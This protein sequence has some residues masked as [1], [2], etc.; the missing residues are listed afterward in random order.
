MTDT[1]TTPRELTP[2][3]YFDEI[4]ARKHE[5]TD[6]YLDQVYANA[7]TLLNK[8]QS[9]GQRSAM[10]KLLFQLDMIAKEREIVKAGVTTFIYR[11]DVKEYID[12]IAHDVVKVQELAEYER[13]VPDAIIETLEKV[14]AYFTSFYVVFTDY[15]KVTEK[16]VEKVRRERDPIL[17]GAFRDA[18]TG[19]TL[20]RFYVL[21]D[22][23]DPYCDL[24]LER[25]VAETSAKFHTQITH[26]HAP[27]T[28]QPN[29]A[30]PCVG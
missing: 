28:A 6:A 7:L 23:V 3:Q 9:T 26:P 24:T 11:T 15:R 20:E 16:Q 10:R 5:A 25:M 1:P 19:T 12:H 13:E 4:K 29:P 2:S 8:Y 22:W 17:F 27:N 18:Q 14:K 30:T 21:G